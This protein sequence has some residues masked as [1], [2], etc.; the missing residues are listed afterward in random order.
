MSA[1]YQQIITPTEAATRIKSRMED[2]DRQ[3]QNILDTIQNQTEVL[4]SESPNNVKYDSI[5]KVEYLFVKARIKVETEHIN[6]KCILQSLNANDLLKAV[7]Q[8]RDA[9]LASVSAKLT[10]IQNDI[11]TL[12]KVVYTQQFQQIK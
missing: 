11:Q 7:L 2:W 5:V 12:Q 10:T 4:L 1:D 9:Y 3:L 6:I 8:K